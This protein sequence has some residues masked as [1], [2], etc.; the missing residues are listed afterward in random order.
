[1]WSGGLVRGSASLGR[2]QSSVAHLRSI[3]KGELESIKEAGTWKKERII[4]SKQGA[5]ITVEG[6]STGIWFFYKVHISHLHQFIVCWD[7]Y[8]H[9]EYNC[10]VFY[11]NNVIVAEN[12][13]R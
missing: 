8:S 4:T 10:C 6:S 7:L 5:H 11:E 3:L 9:Y 2:A 13:S 1:M 12:A